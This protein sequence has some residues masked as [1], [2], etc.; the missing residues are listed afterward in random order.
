MIDNK[1]FTEVIEINEDLFL[2]KI[3]NPQYSLM[4]R[5]PPSTCESDPIIKK[6]GINP[7]KHS[8]KTVFIIPF[9]DKYYHC[10]VEIIPLVLE[11]MNR[12]K[13]VEII[14]SCETEIDPKTGLFINLIKEAKQPVMIGNCLAPE[15][16]ATYLADIMNYFNIPFSCMTAADLID[17]SFN[18]C[19]IFYEKAFSYDDKKIL[20]PL[21]TIYIRN[22]SD[23]PTEE[24]I[25]ENYRQVFSLEQHPFTTLIHNINLMVQMLPKYSVIKNTK[26]Y[27]SRKNFSRRKINNEEIVEEYFFNKGYEIVYLE[28]LSFLDQIK[29]V[30]ESE[31]IVCILGTSLVNCMT[32]SKETY[33]TYI[34]P[35]DFEAPLYDYIFN[36]YQIKFNKII[37]KN[38]NALE[39]ILKNENLW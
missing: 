31:R 24:L 38:N 33:I 20:H 3:K 32:C 35:N 21:E 14:M 13:D 19:Y 7:D 37:M 30:Q 26:I 27:I 12:V 11:V 36:R 16:P 9:N 10:F 4:Y 29:K 5:H 2:V 15:N 28:N 23:R 1:N 8:D 18:Y 22:D 6:I 17:R 34:K 39:A 25:V